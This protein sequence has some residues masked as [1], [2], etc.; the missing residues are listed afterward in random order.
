MKR[1]CLKPHWHK[2]L[3]FFYIHQSQLHC[4]SQTWISIVTG[5]L[6]TQNQTQSYLMGFL[7]SNSQA[8]E[9]CGQNQ[10]NLG[11][12]LSPALPYTSPVSQKDEKTELAIPLMEL[13]CTAFPERSHIFSTICPSPRPY[14]A[15]I[16]TVPPEVK[17]KFCSAIH[18]TSC[19]CQLAL[20]ETIPA[21][22]YPSV[23]STITLDA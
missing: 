1:Q 16:L 23:G 15:A 13:L 3:Q 8:A 14:T 2:V 22:V 9:C 4:P 5:S 7:R 21:A 19:P 18:K 20:A 12:V 17:G 11:T 10:K 6:Q